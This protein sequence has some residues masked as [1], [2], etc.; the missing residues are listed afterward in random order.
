MAFVPFKAYP[1]L[2]ID[3]DTVLPFAVTFEL[4]KAKVNSILW[5]VSGAWFKTGPSWVTLYDLKSGIGIL[6]CVYNH[7]IYTILHRQECLCHLAMKTPDY[8]PVLNHA[9][10]KTPGCG[11]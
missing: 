1:P 2:V 3:P 9:G 4:F 8:D 11:L 5:A 6:A 7:R 10:K